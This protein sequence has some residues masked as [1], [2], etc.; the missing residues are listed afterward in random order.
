MMILDAMVCGAFYLA[1]AATSAL[2]FAAL[3]FTSWCYR[4]PR[5]LWR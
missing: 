1:G 5:G 4:W 3:A 2:V